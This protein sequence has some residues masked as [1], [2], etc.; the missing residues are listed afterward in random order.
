M[1]SHKIL[2]CRN[3]MLTSRQIII[4]L[5]GVMIFLPSMVFAGASVELVSAAGHAN[6]APASIPIEADGTATGIGITKIIV[7]TNSTLG[8]QPATVDGISLQLTSTG[9]IGTGGGEFNPAWITNVELYMENDAISTLSGNAVYDN[10]TAY[11]DILLYTGAAAFNGTGAV[12]LTFPASGQ[13][14]GSPYTLFYVVFDFVFGGSLAAALNMDIGCEITDLSASEDF[15]DNGSLANHGSLSVFDSYEASVSTLGNAVITDATQGTS[16]VEFFR[17]DLDII[18]A[19]VT[20]N[21]DSVKLHLDGT[22]PG[23]PGTVGTADEYIAPGGVLIY[24]DSGA[25]NVGTFGP[26]DQQIGAATLSGGYATIYP[27]DPLNPQNKIAITDSTIFWINANLAVVGYT[28]GTYVSLEIEDPSTDISWSDEIYDIYF[29]GQIAGSEYNHT[30]YLTSTTTTPV[31]DNLI[32]ILEVVVIDTTPPEVLSSFPVDTSINERVNRYIDVTFNEDMD[33]GTITTG[34]FSLTYNAGANTVTG[35][36]SYLGVAQTLR[37]IPDSILPSFTE[38]TATVTTGVRDVATVPNN[39]LADYVFTFYTENAP[40]VAST[41]PNTDSQYNFVNLTIEAIFGE[42]MDVTTITTDKLVLDQLA[43][44]GGAVASADLAGT[45]NYLDDPDNTITFGPSVALLPDK[46]YRVTLDNTIADSTANTIGGNTATNYI[47]EFKTEPSPSVV[48]TIPADTGQFVAVNT[49]VTITFNEDMNLPA[50]IPDNESA[51][52]FYDDIGPTQVT[53]TITYDSGTQKMTFDPDTNL[54]ANA[55]YT[56]TVSGNITDLT[57]NSLAADYVFSFTSEGPPTIA[58]TSPSNSAQYIPVNVDITA[59]FAEDMDETTVL[60]ADFAVESLDGPAGTPTGTIAGAF[61]YDDGTDTITFDPTAILDAFTWY[62]ATIDGS[63]SDSTGS[64]LTTDYEYEFQTEPA[65]SVAATSPSNLSQFNLINSNLS[66]TFAENMD[67]TTVI[68]ANF[69]LDSLD[70][71]GGSS[72]GTVAGAFSY[73]DGT[74][75]ISF[76]PTALLAANIWFRVTLDTN[77]T[78]Q[79]GNP[80]AADYTFEFQTEPAPFVTSTSPSDNTQFIAVNT[81]YSVVF[82]E[83]M[84]LPGTVPDDEAVIT[85][86]DLSGP[87]RINGTISYNSGTSTLT[88]NPAANLSA[89]T[90]YTVT[91]IGSV[92]DLTGNTLGSNNVLTFTTEPP[93]NIAATTPSNTAQYVEVNTDVT[94]TFAENMDE[95]TVVSG[96]FSFESLDGPLGTVT[97]TIAGAFGYN[98]VT[99]VLTFNPTALLAANTWF[100]VTLDA[101]M[102]DQTGNSIGSDYLFEFQTEPAPQVLTTIPS[103]LSNYIKVN[104][105]VTITFNEEMNL[106]GSITDDESVITFYDDIGPDRINGTIAYNNTLQQ[107]TITPSALLL[108]ETTY[109]VTVIA[110]ITDLTGNPMLSDYVFNF[111]IE[112]NPDIA[113]TYPSDSATFIP[114]DSNITVK[115]TEDMDEATVISANFA[116][117]RLNGPGGSVVAGVAGA[118]SYN[119]SS[120]LITFDPTALLLPESWYRVTVYDFMTDQSGNP[121]LND[122]SFEFETEPQPFIATTTP[123]NNAQTMTVDTIFSAIFSEN[124]NLP[125]TITD[126]ESV[127][128]FYDDIGPDR[129]NGSISYNSGTRTLEFTPS[130]VLVADTVYTVTILSTVADMTGN[131]LGPDQVFIF[132]T[133][134][135]PGVSVVSPANNAQFVQ[136]NTDIEVTFAEDMD[137]TTVT[138]GTFS[139]ESLSGQLGTVTG[140]VSGSFSYTDAT[141]LL[142]FDPTALLDSSTWYRITLDSTIADSTGNVLGF[143]RTYEFQTEQPP[144]IL[145]TQPADTSQ[146]ISVNTP[147]VVS[148]SEEMSLPGTVLDDETVVTVY[149]GATRILSSSI[150]YSSPNLTFQ[151]LSVLDANTLYTVTILSAAADLSGNQLGG[152]FEFEFTTEPPTNIAA[153]GPSNGAQFVVVDVDVTVT[154][155]ENM[156]ETTVIPAR[157]SLEELTD[158]GGSV[159]STVTGSFTYNDT[160]NVLTF[161]P[162]A[163]LGPET[164]YRATVDSAVTDQTGNSIGSDYIFEF[165]TEP[166]PIVLNTVPSNGSLFVAL[167]SAVTVTFSSQM[168]LLASI[169]DDESVITFY[170]DVGPNRIDATS[171]SYDSGTQKLTFVPDSLLSAG[172]GYTVTVLSGITNINGNPMIDDYV[173]TFTAEPPPTVTTTI[174]A[175]NGQYV[176]VNT[177]IVVNFSEFLNLPATVPDDESVIRV[178]AGA[179]PVPASSIDYNTSIF[180]LT[181]NPAVN[182]DAS[183]L[184]TVTID[185]SIADISGNTLGSDYVF[186][187]TS[188]PYTNI[189]ATSPS[190]TAQYIPISTNVTVT[191]AENMDQAT[192]IPANFSLEELD[193]QAGAVVPPAISGGLTYNDGINQLSFNPS[194]LLLADTWYRV[195]VTDSVT[196][197]SGNPLNGDFVM[198]FRTEPPPRITITT[199][200]DNAPFIPVNTSFSAVFSEDMNLPASITDNESVITFYDNVGPNIINGT[201]AYN[202]GSQTIT[203]TPSGLLDADTTYD[204]TILSTVADLSGNT[205]G[206]DN[207]FQFSTEPAPTIA[208]TI[209]ANNAQY[210][211]VGMSVTVTFA[212]TMDLA[213]IIAGNIELISLDGQG[214]SSTGTITAALS[215]DIPSNTLTYDPSANLASNTWF[216]VTLDSLIAD[217]TGND[218]GTDSIFEFK[219]EPNPVIAAAVPSN[220]AQYVQ[221]NTNIEITFAENMDETTIIPGN[222]AMESLDGAGGSVTGTIAGSFS[223][224]YNDT[225]NVLTFDPTANLDAAKWYRVTLD[226]SISDQSGNPLGSDYV[227]EFQ[228][229]PSPS[230]VTTVPANTAQYIQVD[231]EITVTFSEN[232]D[233]SPT[234][235]DNEVVITVY[236]GATRIMASAIVYDSGNQLLTFTPAALLDADTIYAVTILAATADPTGNAMAGDYEFTFTTEPHTIVAATTPINNAP[237]VLVNS[238]VTV[239]FAEDMNSSTVTDS[240]FAMYE[241][242]VQG[243]TI[244]GG[245]IAGVFSYSDVSNM[246]TF[247]PS[248][249]LAPYTWYRAIVDAAVEDESGNTLETDY[250]FEFRTEPATV[251]S[252][253]NPIDGEQQIPVNQVITVTF[254]E[255]MDESTIIPAN[256]RLDEL[257]GFGGNPV[258]QDQLTPVIIDPVAITFTPAYNDSNHTLSI[259]PSSV[260]DANTWYRGTVSD[261]VTDE[262]GNPLGGNYVFEFKTELNPII[263]STSPLNG[264]D[265]VGVNKVIRITFSDDMDLALV[266]DTGNYAFYETISTDAVSFTLNY[267]GTGPYYVE[268]TPDSPLNPYIEYTIEVSDTLEDTTGNKLPATYYLVFTTELAPVVSLPTDGSTESGWARGADIVATFSK[269]MDTTTIIPGVSFIVQDNA[270]PPNTISGT[271]TFP[272]LQTAIFDPDNDLD[273][274]KTYTVTITTAVTDTSGLSLEGPHSWELVTLGSE[275]FN[276]PTAINNHITSDS[277]DLRIFIPEPAIL[278]TAITVE[279]FTS[280]GRKVATLVDDRPYSEIMGQLPLIWTGDNQAGRTL[281]PGLYIIQIKTAD[282]KKVLK[283]MITR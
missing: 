262:S 44:Q 244:Q 248:A 191:F 237:F 132:S 133:E 13:F 80:L 54:L 238:S 111:S 182:L 21:L 257:D 65:P 71:P 282:Y 144:Q 176:A 62:R 104:D 124:M 116:M 25:G 9:G 210:V 99:N 83:N 167:N 213:T 175:N 169:A 197:E 42:A 35:S 119:D 81:N 60:T 95:T 152:D 101:N 125:G 201:I 18:E 103:N 127:I 204:V 72:T 136:V 2:P 234:L 22:F 52:T 225:S 180:Q 10:N 193:G 214:G 46:W 195:T 96:N 178:Y 275:D 11:D 212:E 189:A 79:T 74:N 58:A 87:T 149:D 85:F 224:A 41:Y 227:I 59:T 84:N 186:I 205:L 120:D 215:Y 161:D 207:S 198:E 261:S 64:L 208:S 70:G 102:T 277:D 50:S 78:D 24:D 129:I 181:F 249:V 274:Q 196:D 118:F 114:I 106:P 5:L 122:Y 165:K 268:I 184:Y 265:T 14:Y 216:R 92:A 76:N 86:Y 56:I 239:T 107:I 28:A 68:A 110:G 97:G 47:W 203:F 137:E 232:M 134:L 170:D 143:D 255:D 202:S 48:N 7:I 229:E 276:E 66:V 142:S 93:T 63:V 200:A 128:T 267:V 34:N 192:I 89:S 29:P 130:S 179:V 91:V 158:Q 190:D 39:M 148:F 281:A 53:G 43:A 226:A 145:S 108:A 31:A 246:I 168:N 55:T 140:T 135:N 8:D 209:P 49:D 166:A 206:A 163:L 252:A 88:F 77:I 211:E 273:Y 115:F 270:T 171:I 228:T 32:E 272:N 219:T 113:A 100:R 153:T 38:F 146:F 217:N 243:G 159:V 112:P 36:V 20:G 266:E 245:E 69:S 154:F 183:T 67:E 4:I 109:T 138:A 94:V 15:D 222:F 231:S 82:S 263:S 253:T 264:A 51:I 233:L 23:V 254:A 139:L 172:T 247:T 230:V 147:I 221:V 236:D 40:H 33:P 199:P 27:R 280:T 269:N 250:P 141:D 278:S 73:N 185:G 235:P 155:S 218:L 105:P 6:I 121:L 194:G 75:I 260:L 174:P 16:D 61:S 256:F 187:F 223:P 220:T 123:A 157:F 160:S 90:E 30:A 177:N 98:D 19:G 258:D 251:V 283:V 37:F 240:E 173:I 162:T 1:T 150:T 57:S 242:D 126:N 271:M 164:W 188:D 17:L 26:G 117:S 241:L 12:N 45:F 259:A 151:P 3:K 279:I 156:D 131:T